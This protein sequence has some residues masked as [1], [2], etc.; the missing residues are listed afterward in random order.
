MTLKTGVMV[1]V[2]IIDFFPKKN[3]TDLKLLNGSVF[4]LTVLT[5]LC[6][7]ANAYIVKVICIL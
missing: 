1:L 7:I 2:S 3:L 5:T 4:S 6:H